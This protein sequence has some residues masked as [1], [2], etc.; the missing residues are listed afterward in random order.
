MMTVASSGANIPSATSDLAESSSGVSA[1][2]N[3]RPM[4]GFKANH[5]AQALPYAKATKS[6]TSRHGIREPEVFAVF[7]WNLLLEWASGS[8]GRPAR[9]GAAAGGQELWLGRLAGGT[10]DDRRLVRPGQLDLMP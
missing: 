3:S 4:C 9:D 8:G 7:I 2:V 5:S 6:T 10:G 1:A